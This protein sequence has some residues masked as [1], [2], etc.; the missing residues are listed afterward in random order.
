MAGVSTATGKLVW[1][2][3]FLSQLFLQEFEW[4]LRHPELCHDIVQADRCL[5]QGRFSAA[6]V[7]FQVTTGNNHLW[8]MILH[9]SM[10]DPF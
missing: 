7:L 9:G 6:L 4:L 8:A 3:L 1:E 5:W 2:S 10:S